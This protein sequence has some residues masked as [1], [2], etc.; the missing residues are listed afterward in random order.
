M[1]RTTGLSAAAGALLAWCWLRLGAPHAAA[2]DAVWLIAL[3]TLPALAPTLRRRLAALV[4]AVPLAV[5]AAFGL[6]PTHPGRLA[7]RFGGGFLE[8]YDVKLPFA[9][10]AHPRMEGVVLIALFASTAVVALAIAARRPVLTALALLVAAGWPATLLS[11]PDD[12]TRGVGI[13]AVVLAVVVGLDARLPLRRL[14][15]AAAVGLVVTVTALGVSHSTAIASGQ[16]LHWQN[17]DF[18]SKPQ[19]PVG[20]AY[21]W[22]SNYG[23]LHFPKK[24][25][26]VLRISA[27]DRPT[28]WRAT[29]LDEF[30]GGNWYEQAPPVTAEFRTGRDELR[31]DPEF[32]KGARDSD[33][34]VRQDVAVG[35]LHDNH[36]VGASVP[37]AYRSG[38]HAAQY[39]AGGLAYLQDRP[40]GPG[41]T[42][43]VWS[44]QARPTPQEL[45]RVKPRYPAIVRA[46][47]LYVE[48]REVAPP[49]G[50]PGREAAVDRL[51][52]ES[53]RAR[54]YRGVYA[55]ARRV[56]GNPANPYA[57]ALE[58]EA[59]FRSGAFR[60]DE[61]PPPSGNTPALVAFVM[62][63]HAG[64]CQHFAGAMA[65]M[66]RYLGIPA[67]VAAGFTSGTYEAKRHQWVVTDHDA[68]TWVEAWF[69]GYGWLP[70]DPTPGRGTLAGT[71]TAA[72]P[73]FDLSDGLRAVQST[74]RRRRGSFDLRKLQRQKVRAAGTGHAHAPRGGS[75][76]GGIRGLLELLVLVA[77]AGAALVVAVKL[78]VRKRRYLTRDPRRLAAAYARELGDFAADQGASPPPSATLRE[79]SAL[80]DREFGVSAEAFAEAAA[81]ARYG[82]QPEAHAAARHARRELRRLKGDLR[83]SLSRSERT[84][85]LVSLRSLGLAG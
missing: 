79:L 60:Y 61:T 37:V 52:A 65:L 38:T 43:T 47:D 62:R 48:A 14:A 70:F 10:A 76:G 42:Y 2:R 68:H 23:G 29:T 1:A 51:F 53:L 28:Y 40:L 33:R 59:W 20:V 56:V 64:Y 83:R 17:W 30:D 54:Q 74:L 75:A 18:Y 16:V 41:D 19:K 82:P 15:A 46:N 4:V 49:F 77:A 63:T 21:V 69:A 3:A 55:T 22:S 8:F 57:A 78:A 6:W 9:S 27:P 7:G 24:V 26:T 85:G 32:P 80:I 5:H 72:S 13:L 36:L 66:L 34:W 44:F 39:A 71:Y 11:G 25:T 45:A 31:A 81:S 67:R 35:A 12:L 58:L 73:H 84:L 50:T